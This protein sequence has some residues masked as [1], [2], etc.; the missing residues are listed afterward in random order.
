MTYFRQLYFVKS[1]H[2]E[3]IIRNDSIW[4]NTFNINASAESFKNIVDIGDT[5]YTTGGDYRVPMILC[6][7]VSVASKN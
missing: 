3:S 4:I 6:D 7:D 1:L 2:S 5:L